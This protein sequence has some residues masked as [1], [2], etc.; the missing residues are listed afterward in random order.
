[1]CF[2]KRK[3]PTRC[4]CVLSALAAICGIVMIAFSFLLTNN[5]VLD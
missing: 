5:R 3:T 1:M 2:E 4:I